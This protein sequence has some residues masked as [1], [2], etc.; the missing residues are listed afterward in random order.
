LFTLDHNFWTQNPSRSYQVSKYL[1]CSLVSN[2]N[3][4]KNTTI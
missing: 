3:F 1:D 4:S 2:K